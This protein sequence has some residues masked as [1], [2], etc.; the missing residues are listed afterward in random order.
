MFCGQSAENFG[1]FVLICCEADKKQEI[2]KQICKDLFVWTE[3]L[4]IGSDNIFNI[5]F[6]W[7]LAIKIV[8]N[9][10]TKN[11]NRLKFWI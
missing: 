8:H 1:Y 5:E 4:I 11:R 9:L 3:L 2:L 10:P 6:N 7:A